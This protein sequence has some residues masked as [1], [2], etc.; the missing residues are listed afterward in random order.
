MLDYFSNFIKTGNPNAEG[1][2]QWHQFNNKQNSVQF[3]PLD[4][5]KI[6]GLNKKWNC[7][8]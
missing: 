3:N 7:E 5:K 4:V 6:S 1:L 8:L 2:P